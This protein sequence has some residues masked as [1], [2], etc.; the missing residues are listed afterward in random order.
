MTALLF[1]QLF[2]K[3]GGRLPSEVEQDQYLVAAGKRPVDVAT[4]F[5]REMAKQHPE[6]TITEHSEVYTIADGQSVVVKVGPNISPAGAGVMLVGEAT[7][8]RLKAN[9]GGLS[10]CL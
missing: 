3:V 1:L 8:A 2:L 10:D 7:R 5:Y 4:C 6:A 9:K